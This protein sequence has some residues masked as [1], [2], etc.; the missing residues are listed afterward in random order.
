MEEC[1]IR[2]SQNLLAIIYSNFDHWE[3]T[4]SKQIFKNT[5]LSIETSHHKLLC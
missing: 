2:H 5:D 4:N 3:G 1:E